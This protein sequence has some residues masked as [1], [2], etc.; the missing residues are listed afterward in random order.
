MQMTLPDAVHY[1]EY[2][3]PVILDTTIL[4]VNI[5]LTEDGEIVVL[6]TPMVNMYFNIIT[7]VNFICNF[8]IIVTSAIMFKDKGWLYQSIVAIFQSL[9]KEM[10]SVQALDLPSTTTA[11]A[12]TTPFIPLP[13]ILMDYAVTN[14]LASLPLH[15]VLANLAGILIL[16]II[17]ILIY[18]FIVPLTQ[19]SSTIVYFAVRSRV[20][21][22]ILSWLLINY[23]SLIPR[24]LI[25]QLMM[26]YLQ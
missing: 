1:M 23:S 11:S 8:V 4:P 13:S 26:K 22:R 2:K 21:V 25:H 24:K 20:R 18:L 14:T 19:R 9:Q 7:L 6:A 12:S 17:G 15:I 3:T 10:S 5:S 16:L